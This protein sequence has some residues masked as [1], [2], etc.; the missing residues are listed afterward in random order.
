MSS[1]SSEDLF[2]PDFFANPGPTYAFLRDNAPIYPLSLPDGRTRWIITR[3]S[4]ALALLKDER[5]V[6]DYRNA[7]PSD[8]A[9]PQA[10][11]P[12]LFSF[13]Q[14]TL[15]DRDPPDHTRLRML[16]SRAFTPRRVE[17]LR[18][19][20]QAIAISL[21]DA[22]KDKRQMDLINDYASPFS[23]NVIV[24]MLG[25]PTEDRDMF[26]KW[27][28]TL[29]S[30]S[31]LKEDDASVAIAFTD[32]SR[33][34]IEK[35]R[36]E[37][38]D[39]LISALIEVEEQGDKLSED[40]LLGMIFL[41]P[42]AGHQTTLNLIGNGIFTLLQHLE[43]LARLKADINLLPSAIEEILRYCGPIVTATQRYAR[44]DVV[45]GEQTIPRGD[46]I[47]IVLS[48]AN[49][50]PAH[51]THPEAFDIARDN[52]RHLEFG[53]GI[54]YCLGASLARV[55]GQIAIA[56]LLHC[57]PTLRLAVSPEALAWRSGFLMHG[58]YQLPLVF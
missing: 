45:I 2:S 3:Y 58:L 1:I 57:M 36:K 6:K 20:I 38:K 50:D 9:E 44:E 29:W 33:Q 10:S 55:E 5:F 40:E 24:E 31:P 11:L 12:D 51:F 4:D 34:L 43:Q 27:S 32:Y 14:S 30:D 47:M 13:A 49:Q 39:D 25:I 41:L 35:R 18:P 28:D 54:H 22:V 16:V 19:R 52:N 56:T 17:Q 53:H 42:F 15:L 26:R 48:S 46:S 37:P 7:V 23:M 21:L 8:M